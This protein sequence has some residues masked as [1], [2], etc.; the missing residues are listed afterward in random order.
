[1]VTPARTIRNGK[2]STAHCRTAPRRSTSWAAFPA[3]QLTT[4][5]CGTLNPAVWT[6][7]GNRAWL[8]VP[9]DGG[10]RNP[11]DGAKGLDH[12]ARWQEFRVDGGCIVNC[13]VVPLPIAGRGR[14]PGA[15]L[16]SFLRVF[17]KQIREGAMSIIRLALVSG[18]LIG[19]GVAAVAPAAAAATLRIGEST[20]PTYL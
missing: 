9:H 14:K 8:S 4:V 13:P 19:I 16:G 11:R 5:R 6:A 7:E 17:Q 18:V 2:A 1:M 20:E 10:V 15:P 3:S 12:R